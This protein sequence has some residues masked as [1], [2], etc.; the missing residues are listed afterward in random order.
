MWLTNIIFICYINIIMNNGPIQPKLYVFDHTSKYS[1]IHYFLNSEDIL[2][3]DPNGN[4]GYNT[5]ICNLFKDIFEQDK[6]NIFNNIEI[7]QYFNNIIIPYYKDQKYGETNS[8]LIEDITE[9]IYENMAGLEQTTVI[10]KMRTSPIEFTNRLIRL[11]KENL[12]KLLTPEKSQIPLPGENHHFLLVPI[13]KKNHAMCLLLY[14]TKNG[15]D[16]R[17]MIFFIDPNDEK[18]YYKSIVSKNIERHVLN[19]IIFRFING[20][21]YTSSFEELPNFEY[22][23]IIQT[24]NLCYFYSIYKATILYLIINN[25]INDGI[26]VDGDTIKQHIYGYVKDYLIKQYIDYTK[27]KTLVKPILPEIIFLYYLSFQT[28]VTILQKKHYPFNTYLLIRYNKQVCSN[29]EQLYDYITKIGTRRYLKDINLIDPTVYEKSLIHNQEKQYKF[30]SLTHINDNFDYRTLMHDDIYLLTKNIPRNHKVIDD[31]NNNYEGICLFIDNTRYKSKLYEVINIAKTSV[32]NMCNDIYVPSILLNDDSRAFLHQE[33]IEQIP[34]FTEFSHLI[35]I[36]TKNPVNSTLSNINNY[37]QIPTIK[38]LIDDLNK[39]KI[40]R[41]IHIKNRTFRIFPLDEM[42]K[43]M[44]PLKNNINHCIQFEIYKFIIFLHYINIDIT[45]YIIEQI[46]N[47]IKLYLYIFVKLWYYYYTKSIEIINQMHDELYKISGNYIGFDENTSNIKLL[48]LLN[49]MHSITHHYITLYFLWEEDPIL[50][51]L[52]VQY[53]IIP[54]TPPFYANI[55]HDYFIY[56]NPYNYILTYISL[57]RQQAIYRHGPRDSDCTIFDAS[58]DTRTKENLNKLI[59]KQVIERGIDAEYISALPT[60]LKRYKK[61]NDNKPSELCLARHVYSTYNDNYV[62]DKNIFMELAYTVNSTATVPLYI[63]YDVKTLISK[64]GFIAYNDFGEHHINISPIFNFTYYV[65]II[66]ETFTQIFNSIIYGTNINITNLPLYNLDVSKM[67][68]FNYNLYSSRDSQYNKWV[69]YFIYPVMHIN[70]NDAKDRLQTIFKKSDDISEKYRQDLLSRSNNDDD[71]KRRLN[72][73]IFNRNN[74]IKNNSF[75]L[76]IYLLLY[77]NDIKSLYKDIPDELWNKFEKTLSLSNIEVQRNVL[78]CMYYLNILPP[79]DKIPNVIT[80]SKNDTFIE[81]LYNKN[82][83]SSDN[84]YIICKYIKKYKPDITSGDLTLHITDRLKKLTS[85]YNIEN[86]YEIKIDSENLPAN[87]QSIG[88]DDKYK[89]KNDVILNF[90]VFNYTDTAKYQRIHAVEYIHKNKLY[91]L[92]IVLHNINNIHNE[93]NIL[94]G[95]FIN[96]N[97]LDQKVEKDGR[98][99]NELVLT[100]DMVAIFYNNMVFNINTPDMYNYLNNIQCGLSFSDTNSQYILL[101]LDKEQDIIYNV[102]CSIDTR[103]DDPNKSE[104]DKLNISSILLFKLTKNLLTIDEQNIAYYEFITTQLLHLG[105][106][107]HGILNIPYYLTDVRNT[108]YT[109]VIPQPIQYNHAIPPASDISEFKDYII[110][111]LN[112]INIEYSS[113]IEKD[114]FELVCDG[115]TNCKPMR[116][117]IFLYYTKPK[118]KIAKHNINIYKNLADNLQHFNNRFINNIDNFYKNSSKEYITSMTYLLYYL[119]H[120]IYDYYIKMIYD[121]CNSLNDN[122]DIQIFLSLKKRF[123]YF[124]EMMNMLGH[125]TNNKDPEQ[126]KTSTIY[127]KYTLLHNNLPIKEV[128]REINNSYIV[129][130]MYSSYEF[131]YRIYSAIH[132]NSK[133]VKCLDTRLLKNQS[134]DSTMIEKIISVYDYFKKRENLEINGKITKVSNGKIIGKINGKHKELDIPTL[135]NEKFKKLIEVFYDVCPTQQQNKTEIFRIKDNNVYIYNYNIIGQYSFKESLSVQGYLYT[136]DNTDMFLKY[137]YTV[138][139]NMFMFEVLFGYPLRL[140]QV[141]MIRDIYNELQY[142]STYTIRNMIMGGGKTSVITPMVSIIANSLN[143]PV[144]IILPQHLVND[145]IRNTIKYRLLYKFN[146]VYVHDLQETETLE[147]DENFN[148]I[149]SD[150]EFK[151]WYATQII[152][153][154]N[155][156]DIVELTHKYYIIIDEIDTVINPVSSNFNK[157]LSIGDIYVESKKMILLQMFYMAMNIY[158]KKDYKYVPVYDELL[159]KAFNYFKIYAINVF[160]GRSTEESHGTTLLMVPYSFGKPIPHS[161]YSI[162]EYNIMAM[163]FGH[164]YLFE[165][166]T[167]D[168]IKN[169][170]NFIMKNNYSIKKVRSNGTTQYILEELGDV[171]IKEYLNRHIEIYFDYI[172]HLIK[173]LL[174]DSIWVI[175]ITSVDIIPIFEKQVGYSGTTYL[176]L[177]IYYKNTKLE[178]DRSLLKTNIFN[179]VDEDKEVISQTYSTIY[180]VQNENRSFAIISDNFIPDVRGV[181]SDAGSDVKTI[182]DEDVGN[183]QLPSSRQRSDILSIDQQH[184]QKQERQQQQEQYRRERRELIRRRQREQLLL[185]QDQPV[186]AAQATAAATPVVEGGT[187]EERSVQEPVVSSPATS[188]AASLPSPDPSGPSGPQSS[189]KLGEDNRLFILD[190]VLTYLYIIF[191]IN[192]KPDK[193]NHIALIDVGMILKNYTNDDI[194]T[195]I[196]KLNDDTETYTHK[197]TNFVYFD[198]TNQARQCKISKN[199][200]VSDADKIVKSCQNV[201]NNT[202]FYYDSLHIIGT[203]IP[204]QHDNMVGVI[205][206]SYINDLSNTLQGAFR[207]R[208]LLNNQHIY[209]ILYNERGH[210]INKKDYKDFLQGNG[211]HNN[212]KIIPDYDLNTAINSCIIITQ[213]DEDKTKDYTKDRIPYIK[214]R[215]IKKEEINIMNKS[216]LLLLDYLITTENN[217]R[218]LKKSSLLNQNLLYYYKCTN[219]KNYILTQQQLFAH[220]T[221]PN[222][223]IISYKLY[224]NKK[225]YDDVSFYYTPYNVNNIKVALSIDNE[226]ITYTHE[227]DIA[228]LLLKSHNLQDYKQELGPDTSTNTEKEKEKEKEKNKNIDQETQSLQIQL[229]NRDN[230]FNYYDHPT[231]PYSFYPNHYMNTIL[232]KN[233]NNNGKYIYT[234]LFRY[235]YAK[236]CGNQI[237]KDYTPYIPPNKNCIP[238]QAMETGTFV[239][240]KMYYSAVLNRYTQSNQ[241]YMVTL[242]NQRRNDDTIEKLTNSYN[243]FINQTF[244]S[245]IPSPLIVLTNMPNNINKITRND[246]KERYNKQIINRRSYS[247]SVV[248]K[249]LSHQLDQLQKCDLNKEPPSQH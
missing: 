183:E 208:K 93:T 7:I 45:D 163:V 55:I 144:I 210:E 4:G 220:I 61:H 162:T 141:Q 147:L 245:R 223:D 69:H 31:T 133:G 24:S 181:S 156:D 142:N 171:N 161:F 146:T 194:T 157:I 87:L 112:K 179:R 60:L 29:Y 151:N 239:T 140:Q 149:F 165:H 17:V 39:L 214:I 19:N 64:E 233:K 174:K 139:F 105:A 73:I 20:Y 124:I 178:G 85:K 30:N 9:K 206:I 84:T 27:L 176:N 235:L 3:G 53:R 52:G 13:S 241:L 122:N 82:D 79:R 158:H 106:N 232:L 153:G 238:Y 99:T 217:S 36:L 173:T 247:L 44:N 180:D 40:N 121:Y 38:N 249:V 119:Q 81:Y 135:D 244:D 26:K 137:F 21:I 185:Q 215:N 11:I 237:I 204:N 76:Q 54:H 172:I 23:D 118:P 101:F 22:I 104:L 188:P 75:F 218:E 234:E 5:L 170:K 205:T 89:L 103:I 132:I 211:K 117:K 240:D 108:N 187:L 154:K 189:G 41:R 136:R 128:D 123:S 167:E 98:K 107:I 91:C 230:Y 169:I 116:D 34:F 201:V 95:F 203:D 152:K 67:D 58:D 130:I 226:N 143:K 177:P 88:L 231:V 100:E 159:N 120:N 90:P 71:Y 129:D 92:Y 207:L 56:L 184:Q 18:I 83:H 74:F 127:D 125:D 225:L 94:L 77:I 70:L 51:M 221:T 193:I 15:N 37:T 114:K 228:K 229:S 8:K 182:E 213:C 33:G 196:Q 47:Y 6:N 78:W 16:Y 48:T 12:I 166:L 72:N 195:R 111:F 65:N 212:N 138:E 97:K 1:Y 63:L 168:D 198:N 200:Q 102:N 28:Y 10:D 42:K 86:Y 160:F 236:S 110:G 35:A 57:D 126:S 46:S 242:Y 222:T 134:V 190:G 199:T 109:V 2:T 150:T 62:N 246:I 227:T 248:D 192:Y 66:Y 175:N 216:L 50:Y 25:I 113:L 243:R 148:Y 59:N 32:L 68:G 186:P 202:L 43:F 80:K 219:K 49:N 96:K 155:Y 209:P 131:R 191:N 115:L 197:I 14:I 224:D 145:T 164:A